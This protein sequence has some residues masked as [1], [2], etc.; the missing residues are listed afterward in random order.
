MNKLINE[1][2][3]VRYVIKINGQTVSVPF[4]SKMLA[5]QHIGNLPQDQQLLAEIVP[6]TDNGK[7][8][9]FG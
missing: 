8:I 7:Q 3:Q 6:V 9:L 4:A 5:E 1:Q 2:E